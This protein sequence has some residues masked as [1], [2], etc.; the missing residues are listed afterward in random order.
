M[1]SYK[2]VF[3]D[4]DGTL[5]N[6]A[7]HVPAATAQYLRVLSAPGVPFVIVTARMP[8][9][10][11]PL[12]EEI[13]ISSPI[14]CYGGALTLDARHQILRSVTLSA[15]DTAR[16]MVWV[17]KKWPDVSCSLYAQ[18][19]WYAPQDKLVEEES[20][21]T[22]VTA[23]PLVCN[24]KVR[25]HKV[26]LMVRESERCPQMLEQLKQAFSALCVSYSGFGHIEIT[27]PGACKA[28]ALQDLCQQL[29]IPVSQSVAFG[30]SLNDAD[31]LRAAGLGVAV[32]NA[33]AQV[34]A[35]ADRICPSNE[36]EGVRQTLQELFG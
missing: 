21:I 19:T 6:S 35:A 2:M 11:Y 18:N 34:R 24:Q 22:G 14:I 16:V 32:A 36:E 31:M 29:H 1:C 27:A 15:T 7:H 28:Q 12:Q 3:S 8:Q 30:D 9:A 23:Q 5:L 10:A 33:A 17:Q 4:L 26:F 20:R 13:G 25:A